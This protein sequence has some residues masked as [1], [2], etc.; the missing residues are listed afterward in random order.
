M[1]NLP[2][3]KKKLRTTEL[4]F[5]SSTSGLTRNEVQTAVEEEIRMQAQD[6]LAVETAEAK[7]ILESYI[8]GMRNKL[9]DDLSNYATPPEKE[10][11]NSLSYTLEDWLYNE[12]DN[13][14]KGVYL[15][16]LSEIRKLGE[17]ILGRKSEETRRDQVF[18]ELKQSLTNYR[19]CVNDAKFEHIEPE[20]KNK[21]LIESNNLD[22]WS[23]ELILQQAK[24]PKTA[25]PVVLASDIT[26]KKQAFEKMANEILSKPKPAPP[27][28]PTPEQQPPQPQQSQQPDKPA[29]DSNAESKQSQDDVPM[30]DVPSEPK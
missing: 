2:L 12:G 17:P 20:M 28:Q 24:Q 27:P 29:T 25:T 11:F 8:L 21:I 13:V 30:S 9:L 19:N 4:T 3:K 7:N 22:K 18:N 26:T 5:T 6:R 1:N 14:S 15:E 23:E 10:S 16:K